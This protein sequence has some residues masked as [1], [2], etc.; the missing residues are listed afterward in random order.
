MKKQ[1][2]L[3][4]RCTCLATE[5]KAAILGYVN[6]IIL[7]C[8]SYSTFSTLAL[9]FWIT[10]AI[11]HKQIMLLFDSTSTPIGYVTWAHLAPDTEQRLLGDPNFSL[12]PSE[13]NEGGR[14]WIIDFC[15][16]CGG[17]K[18]SI[19]KLRSALKKENINDVHWA[20]R[21]PDYSVYKIGSCNISLSPPPK[22]KKKNTKSSSTKNQKHNS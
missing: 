8:N 22:K 14:T 18:E 16:P 3:L 5:K 21:R 7:M 15:F 20:R 13:W 12:H 1:F 2:N 19:K 10:P 4:T 17:A 11:N 6:M 9:N